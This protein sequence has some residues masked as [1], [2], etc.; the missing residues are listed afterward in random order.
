MKN[1]NLLLVT[2]II[3]L[4]SCNGNTTKE[5]ELKQKELELKEK[6][7][8]QKDSAQENLKKLDSIKKIGEKINTKSEITEADKFEELIGYWFTPHMATINILFKRDKTF[9]LNDYNSILEKEEQ[10]TGTYELTGT[11]LILF[12]SDRPKQKFQFYKGEGND[13]NY[14]IK[15]TGNYFVKG[16]NGDSNN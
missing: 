4:F 6:E 7:L 8:A 13:N 16:E 2:F 1:N 9:L 15:N 14:Y 12:Y 11:T 5:L 3:L 10:L